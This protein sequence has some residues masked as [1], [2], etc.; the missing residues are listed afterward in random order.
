MAASQ[1]PRATWKGIEV[2]SSCQ[3][4]TSWLCLT[5]LCRPALG[6]GHG[7]LALGAD[8]WVMGQ[9]VMRSAPRARHPTHLRSDHEVQNGSLEP[10]PAEAAGHLPAGEREEEVR[11]EHAEADRVDGLHI[12]RRALV[13]SLSGQPGS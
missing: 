9:K 4:M 10:C 3:Q 5:R 12:Q 8:I 6:R 13:L 2:S 1:S 11:G 7:E